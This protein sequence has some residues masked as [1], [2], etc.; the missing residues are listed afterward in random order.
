MQ[1]IIWLDNA[2][3][4]LVRLRQFIAI[5]NPTAAQKAA[6]I[7]I[8]ATEKLATVPNFGKPIPELM[9]YRDLYIA[10]GTALWH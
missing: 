9:D 8:N 4:D 1:R 6:K 7:I 3:N 5:K 10:F 2:V